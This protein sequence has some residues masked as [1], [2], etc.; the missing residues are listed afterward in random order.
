[1]DKMQ[2]YGADPVTVLFTTLQ[3]HLV[4][5]HHHTPDIQKKVCD[6]FV[7]SSQFGLAVVEKVVN[8]TRTAETGKA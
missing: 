1:M 7:G 4:P 6:T 3:C 2:T 8:I 5:P